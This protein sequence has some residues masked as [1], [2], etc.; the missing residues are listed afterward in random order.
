MLLK[1]EDGGTFS[2]EIER[3][4]GRVWASYSITGAVGRETLQQSDKRMFA[5]EMEARAW[6]LGEARERGF[7]DQEPYVVG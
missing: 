7:K 4:G 3:D 5:S 1:A 2:A 6:L